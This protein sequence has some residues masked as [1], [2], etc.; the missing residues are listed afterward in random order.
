M[1]NKQLKRL[2]KRIKPKAPR[3]TKYFYLE[4]NV[5]AYES[6][7]KQVFGTSKDPYSGCFLV[8]PTFPDYETRLL[9]MSNMIKE[10]IIK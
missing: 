3:K 5:G 4:G 2:F 8:V 7:A 1:K 9:T 6:L 10:F